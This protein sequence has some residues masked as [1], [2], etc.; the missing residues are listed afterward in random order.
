MFCTA[1]ILGVIVER[2]DSFRGICAV[3]R[4]QVEGVVC[5][6]GDVVSYLSRMHS[7]L[8]L[9]L[10]LFASTVRCP[11]DAAFVLGYSWFFV[12]FPVSAV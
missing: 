2:S 11:A 4:G 6:A 8:I 10:G 9:M 1:V 12:K 5:F 3:R 7:G